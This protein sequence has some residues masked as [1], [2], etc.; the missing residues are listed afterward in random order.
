VDAACKNNT[1]ATIL[2]ASTGQGPVKGLRIDRDIELI[3]YVA[4][5]ITIIIFHRGGGATTV[6]KSGRLNHVSRPEAA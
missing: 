2:L 4:M 5:K 6:L 1:I 3:A